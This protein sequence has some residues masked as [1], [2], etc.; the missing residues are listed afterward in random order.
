[1][2]ALGLGDSKATVV[3]NCSHA[4]ACR[5]TGGVSAGVDAEIM[6]FLSATFF[7]LAI[8]SSD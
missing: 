5:R 8:A 2:P 7:L 1:M 6:H 3:D 4:A